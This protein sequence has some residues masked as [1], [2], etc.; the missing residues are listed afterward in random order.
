MCIRDSIE[1]DQH[2][3]PR[4]VEFLSELPGILSVTY[5]DKED[6][7]VYKRQSQHH[8]VLLFIKRDLLLLRI[9]HAVQMINKAVDDLA[10][11]DGL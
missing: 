6:E 11:E 5:Y 9:R 3:K 7:D 1:T 8:A 4:Q 10:A 2:I